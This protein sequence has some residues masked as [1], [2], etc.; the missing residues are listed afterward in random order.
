MISYW[1]KKKKHFSPARFSS[2][3]LSRSLEISLP[4]GILPFN[5]VYKTEREMR[6]SKGKWIWQHLVDRLLTLSYKT[7]KWVETRKRIYEITND[8]ISIQRKWKSLVSSRREIAI[9]NLKI[10]R[11]MITQRKLNRTRIIAINKTD[12]PIHNE[13]YW[14]NPWHSHPYLIRLAMNMIW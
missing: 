1:D 12:H 2:D 4:K 8:C 6:I 13:R 3:W 5:Y 14:K 7:V 10:Y 11:S 9:H